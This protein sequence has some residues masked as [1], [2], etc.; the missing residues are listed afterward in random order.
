[1]ARKRF[2]KFVDLDRIEDSYGVG[3]KD[4]SV[5]LSNRESNGFDDS[6]VSLF[7]PFICSS[8]VH[9]GFRIFFF[10]LLFLIQC[11]LDFVCF[12]LS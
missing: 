5:S 9:Y 12:F 1:M 4:M 11:C 3:L 10:I 7:F 2:K 8:Y 6:E